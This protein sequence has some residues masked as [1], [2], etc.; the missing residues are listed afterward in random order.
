[1]LQNTIVLPSL[2]LGL[3]VVIDRALRHD[4][5][6]LTVLDSLK[7][8]SCPTS[9]TDEH[10]VLQHALKT[11]GSELLE[12]FEQHAQ[13]LHPNNESISS[14][15]QHQ[16]PK[17][18]CR[19]LTRFPLETLSRNRDAIS[20]SMLRQLS[21]D[22]DRLCSWGALDSTSALPPY[23]HQSLMLSVQCCGAAGVLK[24]LVNQILRQAASAHSG[25]DDIPLDVATSIICAYELS[26][27]DRGRAHLGL[28]QALRLERK[29]AAKLIAKDA[30]RAEIL[31]HLH[32]SV[33]SQL[34]SPE[35]IAH[36]HR[37]LPPILNQDPLPGGLENLTQDVPMLD[38]VDQAHGFDTNMDMDFNSQAIFADSGPQELDSAQGPIDFPQSNQQQQLQQVQRSDLGFQAQQQQVD[39]LFNN[40]DAS[41]NSFFGQQNMMEG[42]FFGS[43]EEQ[44]QTQQQAQQAQQQLPDA[45]ALDDAQDQMVP[46]DDDD[47]WA[48]LG[49]NN[50]Y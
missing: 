21:F 39:D 49:V 4:A 1:M 23:S 37:G 41:S 35:Q 33:E 50:D 44:Q 6:L 42:S 36:L 12:R 24:S 22:F 3:R 31:V 34:A 9:S 13:T 30:Q 5:Q 17:S 7:R 10:T 43:N 2:V 28:L 40:V 32:R 15:F 48:S 38:F 16:V 47:F 18:S 29:N 8:L 20:P 14:F 45:S 11:T 46:M 27:R 25:N 19:T 26:A